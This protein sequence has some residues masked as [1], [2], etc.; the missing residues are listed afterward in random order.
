MEDSS[1][2]K[3]EPLARHIESVLGMLLAADM[4]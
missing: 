1:P 2:G 4:H 3:G